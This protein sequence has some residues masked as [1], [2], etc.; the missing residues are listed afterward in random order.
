LKNK[1]LCIGVWF[2]FELTIASTKS[3]NLIY[4][5][6]K[7][8]QNRK[9]YRSIFIIAFYHD[10]FLLLAL[11]ISIAN[12]WGLIEYIKADKSISSYSLKKNFFSSNWIS[13]INACVCVVY[14]SSWLFWAFFVR[15]LYVIL[16]RKSRVW[17]VTV[18]VFRVLIRFYFQKIKNLFDLFV[19]HEMY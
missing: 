5:S 13:E 17:K 11:L 1:S 10:F 3:P 8:P 16:N 4:C 9:F 2:Q 6:L 19:L 18:N 14:V 7:K 12:K 15:I